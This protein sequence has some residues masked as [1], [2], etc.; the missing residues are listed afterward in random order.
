MSSVPS[1]RETSDKALVLTAALLIAF[2]VAFFLFYGLNT[3]LDPVF[4]IDFVPYHLA[5]RLLAQGDLTPLTNYADSGGFFADTGPF[6]DYFHRYFFPDSDSATRWV[7]LPAYIWI[8]RPLAGLDF[9]AAARV[10][11]VFNALLSVGCVVLLWDARRWSDE[12]R[13]T[14]LGLWR[15]AWFA[16]IGLTFG[17]MLSNLMH[18]QVTGLIF[19]CFCLSYWFLHRRQPFLA[20]LAL[21]LIVPF[22]FYPALFVLY[23]LWRRQWRVVAGTVLGLA[24]VMAVSLLTVGWQG[25]LNYFEIIL[26]E[27]QQGGMAAFNNQSITG[28]LL[29]TFTHGDISAWEDMAMAPWLIALRYGLILLLVAAAVWAMRRVPEDTAHAT[30][31]RDLDLALIVFVMLLASPITWY[32]YYMWVLFPIFVVFDYLL[33]RRGGSIACLAIAYGLI[34]VEGIVVLRPLVPQALDNIWVL[35]VM[36]SQGFFGAV[37]LTVQTLALRR[38]LSA[39]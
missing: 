36:L 5:G 2:A 16:F 39:H 25:N 17:P 4:S 1:T 15:M 24:A 14:P 13:E 20:G 19:L 9:P 27:L 35:R 37:L 34:V 30:L 6:L 29:H 22:K 11:L 3:M 31:A 26:N 10:W 7:Y 33:L 23:F 8:F 38:R 18:G 28:F 32:H 21:G 12:G